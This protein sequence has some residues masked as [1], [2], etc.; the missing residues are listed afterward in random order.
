MSQEPFLPKDPPKST[1]KTPKQCPGCGAAFQHEEASAPGYLPP[2]VLATRAAMT[3]EKEEGGAESSHREDIKRYEAQVEQLPEELRE[4]F[5]P[6][7]STPKS[8]DTPTPSSS[9]ARLICTRCHSLIHHNSLPQN[10]SSVAPASLK[11]LA[12][13]GKRRNAVV[14]VVA[15]LPSF[16]ASLPENLTSVLGS[17]N[18]V[19]LVL[20]KKDVL[21]KGASEQRLRRYIWEVVRAR[22]GAGE[23]PP[24][25]SVHLVSARKNQGVRELAADLRRLRGPQDHVYLT[26][27]LNVGKSELVN[28]LLRISVGGMAHKVTASWIPGTTAGH[29]SVP[30]WRFGRTLASPKTDEP[31]NASSR[32]PTN[33]RGQPGLFDTPGLANP[34]VTDLLSGQELRALT[35]HNQLK[36]L[37][38]HLKP[39]N[40]LL[41]GAMARL[42]HVEGDHTILV[43]IFSGLLPHIT[44]QTKADDLL[45]RHAQGERTILSLGPQTSG[46][47]RIPL[48]PLV[49]VEEFEA[50]G[51]IPKMGTMDISWPGL[52][53]VMLTGSF[54]PVRLRAWAVQG[55]GTGSGMMR[56]S[57][58][59]PYEYTGRVERFVQ[60]GRKMRP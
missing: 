59:M 21:P 46:S 4:Q 54:D 35:P 58:L 10:A 12:I 44:T 7:P 55:Y 37:T 17:T 42:D 39:G 25:A 36:P 26:G 3:A 51:K 16:P 5:S 56:R 60:A 28:A 49:M 13:L 30:I 1:G 57:P 43:T 27:R 11:S 52:G 8:T 41:L 6:T 14:V 20:T 24:V 19:V 32:G 23:M 18:P 53:W 15:D 9:P 29:L 31:V 22:E 45:A 47:A 50:K 34:R 40:S 38:Y 48:P 33:Y 2:S